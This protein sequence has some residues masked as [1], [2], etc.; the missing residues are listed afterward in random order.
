MKVEY[1]FILSFLFLL[2]C[3]NFSQENDINITEEEIG[4]LDIVEP[5]INIINSDNDGLNYLLSLKDNLE[6]KGEY[7][8]VFVS[9][10]EISTYNNIIYSKAK[11]YR[12]DSIIGDEETIVSL[13]IIPEGNYSCIDALGKIVCNKIDAS[14]NP[15]VSFMNLDNYEITKLPSKIISNKTGDCFMISNQN[16]SIEQ[17]FLDNGASLYTHITNSNGDSITQSLKDIDYS[18][19]DSV[20]ELP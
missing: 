10:E 19:K 7:S 3:I 18:V 5:E 9:E 16:E 20:F 1:A 12:F 15:D 17:C 6:Y 2:G 14:D 8:T 4:E 13:Y 11:K